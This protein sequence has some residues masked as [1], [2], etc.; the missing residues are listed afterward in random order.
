M[1]DRKTVKD[2]EHINE[3]ITI[4]RG[5]TEFPDRKNYHTVEMNGNQMYFIP[6]QKVL[7]CCHELAA[8][9]DDIIPEVCAFLQK[10]ETEKKMCLQVMLFF[11][12]YLGRDT[13]IHESTPALRYTNPIQLDD[14]LIHD[15]WMAWSTYL[16]EKMPVV[17]YNFEMKLHTIRIDWIEVTKDNEAELFPSVK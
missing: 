3:K 2:V 4:R 9:I 14:I 16:F 13:I 11:S 5:T 8:F 15:C 10:L 1:A 7:T 17:V 12:Y 6:H